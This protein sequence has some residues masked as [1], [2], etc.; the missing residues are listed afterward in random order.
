MSLDPRTPVLVGVG[1]ADQRCEDPREALEAF[2]LMA[3]AVSQA[4][5]DALGTELSQSLLSCVDS[6]AI[7]QGFWGYPDPGRLVADAVGALHAKSILA[8][9]GILQQTLISNACSDI[10]AGESDVVVVTGGEA[11]YRSLR[12][13]LAGV[14]LEE[15][16]QDGARPDQV[17][18]SPDPIWTD[19]EASRGLSMPVSFFAIMES[20]LRFE[21][22]LGIEAHRDE[23]ARLYASFS[24]VAADNPHA[25]NRSAV[26]AD[27]IRNAEG[28]NRM[29]SFPYT[30]LHNSQWNVDQA[31]ALIFCPVAK[32]QELGVPRHR[33]VFPLAA[34]QS[35]EVVA[36]TQRSDLFGSVGARLAGNAAME[37]AGTSVN[38][39]AHLELYSCFPAAVRI[40]ARELG[41]GSE[42]SLTVTGGMP[43]AGGP[44]NNFVLQGTARL[45]EVLREDPGTMGL[46]SSLSG[47]I[48]KQ[49]FGVWSTEPNPRGYQFA[50]VTAQAIAAEQRREVEEEYQ[51][52]ATIAGYTVSYTKTDPVLGVAICDLPDGKRNLVRSQEGALLDRLMAQE[53]CGLRIQVESDGSFHFLD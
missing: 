4:G 46:V 2:A 5:I 8:G 14:E 50:D 44:L 1:F 6:I 29:L 39:V 31:S 32:A 20:A 23:L 49:G 10:A 9:I 11:K 28:K 51:G 17:L 7:P 45:A 52:P 48:G 42:R 3:Q 30:K 12:A 19:Y 38:Q 40:F 18:S 22:G 16:A 24:R 13:I 21:Q 41:V 53:C 47:I 25:W 35:C 34:T 26:E 37:L 27:E 36:L 33:W 43:F 15:T